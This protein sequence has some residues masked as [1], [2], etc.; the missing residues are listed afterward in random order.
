MFQGI[1]D[2]SSVKTNRNGKLHMVKWIIYI[3]IK[4]VE[5]SDWLCL[6]F[7]INMEDVAMV[8]VPWLVVAIAMVA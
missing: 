2:P 4:I 7:T 5:V 6:L 1:T 8:A 3:R